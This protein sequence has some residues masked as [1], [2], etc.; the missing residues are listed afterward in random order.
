M[1]ASGAAWTAL[2][3]TWLD[4]TWKNSAARL[5]PKH[6][7]P[8]H[9]HCWSGKC[10]T[11]E[12]HSFPK[13]IFQNT[14]FQKN[15]IPNTIFQTQFSKN[16]FPK[17]LFQIIF[18]K[19]FSKNGCPKHGFPEAIFQTQ[20]S[21]DNFPKIVDHQWRSITMFGQWIPTITNRPSTVDHR[22]STMGKRRGGGGSGRERGEEE[23]DIERKLSICYCISSSL[24]ICHSLW[25]LIHCTCT[26]YCVFDMPSQMSDC[27]NSAIRIYSSQTSGWA[28]PACQAMEQSLQRHL[29]RCK[30]CSIREQYCSGSSFN[31]ARPECM[32]W[33][34]PV[35]MNWRYKVSA[36]LLL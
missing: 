35:L 9:C 30:L 18:Q 2:A 8:K 32:R 29:F 10:L 14:V 19:Q 36:V 1:F 15:N 20:F 11:P 16:N 27:V 7:C 3:L 5:L 13:T 21:K 4:L 34:C 33:L 6:A 12:K 31:I 25:N 17:T 24:R 28:S 22:G 23:W 26:A